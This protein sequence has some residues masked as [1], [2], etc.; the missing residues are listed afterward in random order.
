MPAAE[1]HDK[2]G[3]LNVASEL[4]ILREETVACETVSLGV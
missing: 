1:T 2:A 4:G 3:L